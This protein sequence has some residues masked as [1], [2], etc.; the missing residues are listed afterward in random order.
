[1]EQSKRHPQ[2]AKPTARP[3]RR[4]EQRQTRP[5]QLPDEQ[6]DDRLADEDPRWRP[7]R[8]GSDRG[9]EPRDR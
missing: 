4:E 5:R 6:R 7:Q 3:E 1:M 2:P 8:G 9:M